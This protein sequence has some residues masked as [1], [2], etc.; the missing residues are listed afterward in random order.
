VSADDITLRARLQR[1]EDL[2]EIRELLVEYARC[3]DAGDYAAYSELFTDDGVLAAQLGEATGREA[4]RA[5]L[6]DRLQDGGDRALRAAVH[7]IGQ[8]VIRVDGDEAT[9]R[10]VWFFVTYDDG[11]YPLILQLGHYE[12]VLA[13]ERGRWRFKRRT[14]TRQFGYSP[15]DERASFE[16]R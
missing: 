13:R 16:R 2:E 10:V 12:D 1:L 4:I 5:L 15:L 6:E 14:I 9:S 3:L 7:V 11:N 8:P